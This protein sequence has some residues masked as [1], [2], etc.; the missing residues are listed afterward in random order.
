VEV[1]RDI[2]WSLLLK[3]NRTLVVPRGELW[4]NITGNLRQGDWG[5]MRHSD[6]N[7]AGFDPQHSS[8]FQWRCLRR[9]ICTDGPG[10]VMRERLGELLV[11]T[12]R[13]L[14]C[15]K[16]LKVRVNLRGKNLCRLVNAAFA[17]LVYGLSISGLN[18]FITSRDV[19]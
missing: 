18:R 17:K 10:D 8:S 4:V 5:Y 15:P 16:R 14:D 2:S 6:G 1:A 3:G 11:A 19:A 9:C 12:D 13:I 7:G